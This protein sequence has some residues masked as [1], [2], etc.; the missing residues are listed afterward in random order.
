MG[1]HVARWGDRVRTGVQAT[2]MRRIVRSYKAAMNR[3]GEFPI[4]KNI[5]AAVKADILEGFRDV[6]DATDYLQSMRGRIAFY[7]AEGFL[8]TKEDL[9]WAIKRKGIPT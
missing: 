2:T 6:E 4:S 7:T 5:E 3:R 1:P 9:S 8:V